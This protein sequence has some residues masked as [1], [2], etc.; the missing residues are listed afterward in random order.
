MNIRA[1]A[2]RKTSTDAEIRLWHFLRDRRMAG[3][4]FRRQ[5][6][7]GDFVAD[8]ACIECSLIVEADGGQHA[9]QIAQDQQRTAFLEAAGFRV[10]RFWNNEI[11]ANTAAVLES[12][13][14]T[15]IRAPSP[16]PSP[17]IAGERE[18]YSP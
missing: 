11:L 14:F 6:A 3:Y 7:I 13:R 2:L 12:I 15:L 16:R 4:K 18:K 1:R 8:F 5:H 10:L 9:E 17:P